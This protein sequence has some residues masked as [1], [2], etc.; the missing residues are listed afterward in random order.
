[1]NS[2]NEGN[3]SKE[4]QQQDLNKLTSE[5]NPFNFISKVGNFFKKDEQNHKS[6]LSLGNGDKV[7]YDGNCFY[8]YIILFL[9]LV[10]LP[11]LFE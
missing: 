5:L 8:A 11:G 2:V 6:K 3:S 7:Y 4:N 9:F 1:M 10:K